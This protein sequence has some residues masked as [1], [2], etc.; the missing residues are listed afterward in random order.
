VGARGPA[1]KPTRLRV[2]H[3]GHPERI[4]RSEPQPAP[5][6]VEPPPYLSQEARRKWDELAPHLEVMG[7]LTAVDVDLLAAYCECFARWRR[8]A[9]LAASSPPVFRR[10]A[11]PE[12]G[13]AKP[14]G[15]KAEGDTVLARNPLWSQVR[16]AEAALRVMAREFGFTPSARSGLR[17]QASMAGAAERLLTG[18]G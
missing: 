12:G 6:P 18:D 2:L 3:G 13:G 5:L 9:Q 7:V 11:K 16:D 8:L 1:P 4:N 10:G 17:A 15:D 14:E